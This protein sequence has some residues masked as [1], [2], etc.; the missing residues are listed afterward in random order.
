ME[1]GIVMKKMSL[2]LRLGRGPTTMKRVSQTR[3]TTRTTK[4][5]G[6]RAMNKRMTSKAGRAMTKRM[7]S[8]AGRAMTKK[9]TRMG[10]H[11]AL[12]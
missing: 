11:Q 10:N 9:M 5:K 3:T 8:K 12:G 7:T 1:V 6:G 2:S 4:S